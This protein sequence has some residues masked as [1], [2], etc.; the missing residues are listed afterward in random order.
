M[1]MAI[2]LRKKRNFLAR[3]D[4]KIV[5]AFIQL[6]FLLLERLLGKVLF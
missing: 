1:V 5:S 2:M 6:E 3:H 4:D